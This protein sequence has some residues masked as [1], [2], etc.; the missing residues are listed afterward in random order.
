MEGAEEEVEK[1]IEIEEGRPPPASW[2]VWGGLELCFMVFILYNGNHDVHFLCCCILV[3]W[4]FV[5]SLLIRKF[6]IFIFQLV[7]DTSVV[8]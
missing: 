5:S 2:P 3:F 7:K 4:C 6:I 1:G 8:P